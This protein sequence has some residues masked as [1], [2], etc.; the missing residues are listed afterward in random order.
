[1]IKT[2]AFIYNNYVDRKYYERKII[3]A[4]KKLDKDGKKSNSSLYL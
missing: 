3:L 2:V 1:M 4:N